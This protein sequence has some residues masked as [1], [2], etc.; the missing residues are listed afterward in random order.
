YALAWAGLADCYAVYSAFEALPPREAFPK[1]K[2]AASKALAIDDTLA[3]PHAALAYAKAAYDWDR[4]GAEREFKRAIE[5]NPNYATAHSWYSLDLEATGRLE[6]A[7]AEAKRAQEA[8]PLSLMISTLVGKT[9]YS[10]RRYDQAIEQLRKALEMDPNFPRA[11]YNLGMTYG[12]VGRHGEA[13]AECQKAVSLSGGEPGA[14]GVLGYAYALSGKRA[15]AQKVLAELKDLSRRRYVAP[16]DSALIYVGLGDKA[17]ALEWLG[18]AYEDHSLE[19][20]W[21]KVYPQFDPLRGEPRFQ[22]LLRRMGLPP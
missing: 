21:R 7:I 8:D 3:E 12:Q 9:L 2:E 22:D 15:E 10:A 19:P 1:A 20:T 16:Y 6:E 5:L 18:K 4:P 14:L 17:Q 11:H 13:I